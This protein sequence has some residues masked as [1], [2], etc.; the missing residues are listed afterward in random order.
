MGLRGLHHESQR[1]V[2]IWN[3]GTQ[4]LPCQSSEEAMKAG[5]NQLARRKS[6]MARRRQKG[7]FQGRSAPRSTW[8][9]LIREADRWPRN[10]A[11]YD[12]H[13]L[14]RSMMLWEGAAQ[15]KV[16]VKTS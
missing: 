14:V 5:G 4:I 11:R 1:S 13:T 15:L 8:L 10:M 3:E 2:G 16:S 6:M 7:S 9:G 12:V